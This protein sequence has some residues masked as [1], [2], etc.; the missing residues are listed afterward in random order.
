[1]HKQ[2]SYN[3]NSMEGEAIQHSEKNK[4]KTKKEH[5]SRLGEKE[6]SALK[7]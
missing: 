7:F 5:W 4:N 2:K 1:M 3:K 6:S